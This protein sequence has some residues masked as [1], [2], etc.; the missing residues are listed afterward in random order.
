M[1][2]RI[3]LNILID[4]I[5]CRTEL[6]IAQYGDINCGHDTRV[7]ARKA[8]QRRKLLTLNS[9]SPMHAGFN[10]ENGNG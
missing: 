2:K 7:K 5:C 4:F 10:W 1:V 9:R 8:R 3:A 6:K